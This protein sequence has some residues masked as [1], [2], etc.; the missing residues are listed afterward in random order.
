MKPF[1]ISFTGFYTYLIEHVKIIISRHSQVSQ[2][3]EICC[4]PD[5][6]LSL[7]AVV[8][9]TT[10]SLENGF[11]YIAKQDSTVSLM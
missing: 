7:T 1:E 11:M 3:K 4:C 9:D 2:S 10:K 6:T 5:L 8:S